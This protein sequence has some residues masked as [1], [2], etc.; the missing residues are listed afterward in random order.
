L[1][2]VFENSSFLPFSVI[3]ALCF[4][5]ALRKG[6]KAGTHASSVCP[7]KK[8]WILASFTSSVSRGEDDEERVFEQRVMLTKYQIVCYYSY[9]RMLII[10]AEEA[11]MKN[12]SEGRNAAPVNIA[13]K[14]TDRTRHLL[15]MPERC[16]FCGKTICHCGE[17]FVGRHAGLRAYAPHEQN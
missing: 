15:G 17:D 4:A 8:A 13:A 6:E 14:Q 7:Y 1:E 12:N 9:S 2:R 16:W 10:H 11:Y 5:G 3:P